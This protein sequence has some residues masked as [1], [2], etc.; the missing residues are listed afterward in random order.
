MKKEHKVRFDKLKQIGC[1]ACHKQGRFSDA[2]IHHIRKK[3][4]G[5]SLRP[6]HDDTIPLCPMHHNMGNQ[7][8]HLNKKMFERLF[9][10]ELELLKETN[11]KII[12]LETE[13]QLWEK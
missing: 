10:T 2:I 13:T 5:L 4:T 3:N 1:V 11:L 8:V 7:S 12:Q 9:G 6:S